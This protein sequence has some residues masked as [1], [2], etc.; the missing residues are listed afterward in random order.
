GS[1]SDR[2]HV[3][4]P[5]MGGRGRAA[6]LRAEHHGAVRARRRL[7]RPDSARCQARRFAHR[8]TDE[9]RTCG[10]PEN[11]QGDRHRAAGDRARPRRRG[12]RMKRREFITLIGGV[13]PLR[14]SRLAVILFA[15]SLIILWGNA[16][17]A[18]TLKSPAFQQNGH[19]PSKYTCEGEDVSPPLAWEDAPNGA[20][21][22]VLII[23]DPDAPDPKA[24]K[25]V[26]VHWVVY[27]MPPDTKSLPENAGKAR[28]PQGALLGLNDFKK[29]GY[30]GP[31]PPIGRH[32]YFHKLYALDITLDLRDAT[33][34]QIE[35]AMRGHV[36]ANAELIG[37][38]QKGDR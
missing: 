8:A 38:Y 25:M 18:M 6:V 34:S 26:W 1:A 19:I 2:I 22:L 5:R 15:A 35:R 12:D 20:K 11:R 13:S 10:E 14:N 4:L 23:D 37:T 3:R 33:K 31:C 29:T 17:M 16:A 21:S 27:N 7:C 9:V 28:L 30:G 24:P 36:L 32:R